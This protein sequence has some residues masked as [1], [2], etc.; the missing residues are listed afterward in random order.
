MYRSIRGGA[1]G[2]IP[3]ATGI[4]DTSFADATAE[5][6]VTYF[7]QVTAVNE[8]GEGPRSAE[9]HVTPIL[10]VHIN[11]TT[12]NGDPAANYLA[13]IGQVFGVQSSGFAYGWTRD[14]T[15]GA[16]D[17]DAVNS[18]DEI[19]DSFHEMQ[20][21]SS[22]N[23]RWHI[24][25]PNGIYLVHILM[26]DP[27]SSD[28][29]YR[30]NVKGGGSPKAAVRGQPTAD[31]PWVENTITIKVKGGRIWVLNASGAHENKIDAIDI[32]QV[33]PSVNLASGFSGVKG[34]AKKGSAHVTDESLRLTNG[35]RNQAGSAFTKAKLNVASFSTA[36]DFQLANA[37]ADGFAFVLQGVG[38][39]Q[40]GARGDGLGYAGINDSI[41]V[42]FDLFDNNG[43]GNDSTGLYVNGAIPTDVGSVN[44]DN[45]G[46]DFHSGD[47]FRVAISYDGSRL[48]VTITDTITNASATQTYVVDLIGVLGGSKAYAGFTGWFR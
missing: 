23:A 34:I 43:E 2:P 35:H 44:L 21:R 18:P 45:S 14:D 4:A 28:G 7:Y 37:S 8:T 17:Q 10:S 20:Q 39:H 15:S 32:E 22:G 13:D 27:N 42:K 40:R 36:F 24:D 6:G 3:I 19:H 48:K 25:L 29:R 26:G 30:V 41:A 33:L 38:P 9:I 5:F 31:N 11:F 1:E 47:V 16:I 46:I 12:P